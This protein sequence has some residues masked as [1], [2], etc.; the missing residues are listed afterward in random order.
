VEISKKLRRIST[1]FDYQSYQHGE[2]LVKLVTPIQK[3]STKLQAQ[4]SSKTL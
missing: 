3:S 1:K 4:S 2:I